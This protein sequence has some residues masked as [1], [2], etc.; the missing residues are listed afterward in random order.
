MM[1]CISLASGTSIVADG[2][3]ESSSDAL[4]VIG[5][6]GNDEYLKDFERWA[7][8]W[9]QS[10]PETV[11]TKLL[12][13]KR[14][15]ATI[16][17]S[18]KELTDRQHILDW[19]AAKPNSS[20]N[21]RWLVLI[22]HGT[23]QLKIA[24][25]NLEGPDL[26]SDELAKA[27]E[28]SPARWRIFV[29]ASSSGP[30]I[31]TLSG[32]NRIIVTATKSGSEQNLSRFGEYLSQSIDAPRADLDHDG[33]VSILEAFI[34]ASG[35]LAKWY[36]DEGRIASEQALLDDNGDSRGTP[37]NFFRGVRAAKAPSEGLK[38]DGLLA[39][40]VYLKKPAGTDSLS[41]EQQAKATELEQQIETLR[42]Q[43]SE[44]DK[45]VYYAQLEQMLIELAEIL[46]P[47]PTES[48]SLDLP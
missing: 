8:H 9:Q 44:F 17:P 45:V 24:K 13:P 3:S 1:V 34:M 21:E 48:T 6:G 15:T 31:T 23:Y 4:I 41:S 18:Q 25:F 47:S 7:E 33:N 10:F 5:A 36:A 16:D 22:G 32:P 46:V 38:L 42:K 12:G 27:M 29:C 39:N 37:A 20:E 11:N 43:K 2:P 30:F 26:S 35:N 40:R 19:I 28:A 14:K